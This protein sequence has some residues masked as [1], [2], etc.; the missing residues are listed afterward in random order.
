MDFPVIDSDKWLWK[1]ETQ[2]ILHGSEIIINHLTDPRSS[3]EE[4]VTLL[5][6]LF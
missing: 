3:N 4:P 2:T 1:I 6:F 5:I